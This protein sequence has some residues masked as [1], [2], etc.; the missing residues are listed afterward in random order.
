VCF[1][2]LWPLS[3]FKSGTRHLESAVLQI[4]E[5]SFRLVQVRRLSRSYCGLLYFNVDLTHTKPVVW[6]KQ[7]QGTFIISS[8]RARFRSQVSCVCPHHWT[9][10]K[11]QN[12]LRRDIH[13]NNTYPVHTSQ[14]IRG[15]SVIKANRL[16]LFRKIIGFFHENHMKHILT[17]WCTIPNF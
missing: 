3:F 15:G 2:N 1:F 4:S 13:L 7:R 8:S 17:Q 9:C 16:M 12:C 10:F 5:H 11:G 14:N 6:K